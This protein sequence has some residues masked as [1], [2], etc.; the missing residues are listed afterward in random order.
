MTCAPEK[1]R[2][3]TVDDSPSMRALLM[4]ALTAEG[5]HVD[6]ADDG[7]SALDWLKEN[8]R[9]GLIKDQTQTCAG[10]P[11][12]KSV[13]FMTSH[14]PLYP[15]LEDY[16]ALEAVKMAEIELMRKSFFYIPK[17]EVAKKESCIQN[18]DIIAITTS[19]S[20]LDISH[21]G[22][23][24]VVNGRVHLLHASQDLKEVIISPEPL[25]EYLAKHA[26]QTG[27]MISRLVKR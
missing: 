20:G 6:Q 16:R 7:V 24:I 1:T 11:Y 10:K 2:I 14:L 13:S 27:I 23:A 12:K 26:S 21:Q 4:H 15:Q 25:A 18:G 22:F 19:K 8:E 3:L 9:K 17:A 5:F